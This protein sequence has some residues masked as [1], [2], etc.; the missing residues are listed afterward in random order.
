MKAAQQAG[1]HL[2]RLGWPLASRA[3]N[4]AGWRLNNECTLRPRP[5]LQHHRSQVIADGRLRRAGDAEPHLARAPADAGRLPGTPVGRERGAVSLVGDWLRQRPLTNGRGPSLLFGPSCHAPRTCHSSTLCAPLRSSWASRPA[6]A[7]WS[8]H[9]GAC[10]GTRSRSGWQDEHTGDAPTCGARTRRCVVPC[11]GN[12]PRRAPGGPK[13][14]RGISRQ[15]PP[16]VSGRNAH[17]P[18]GG[19][20][21]CAGA[22]AGERCMQGHVS[23]LRRKY[24]GQAAPAAA[25]TSA[26]CGA[27][28]PVSVVTRSLMM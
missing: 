24:P 18:H 22:L 2:Q 14:L 6:K 3:P 17:A 27:L 26:A 12:A 13:R 7:S 23:T 4:P 19:R 1:H 15:G 16:C 20:D 8:G 25:G 10:S 21:C 9:A 11:L 5:H 28:S